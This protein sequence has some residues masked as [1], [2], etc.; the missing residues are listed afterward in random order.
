MLL[1]PLLRQ[2]AAR[3][4]TSTRDPK[5]EDI[6]AAVNRRTLL[7]QFNICG[8]GTAIVRRR[9]HTETPRL[10]WGSDRSIPQPGSR[11]TVRRIGM[12]RLRHRREELANVVTHGF[13]TLCGIAATGVL[14]TLAVLRGDV[15]HIVGAA[16]FG[17]T[18]IVLYSAST[19]YHA[20][21]KQS[22]KDRLRV[23]DHS[24]IYLLI[25]GTYTPFTLAGVRGGWGWALFGVIWGLAAAG[26]LF[27]LFFTGRFRRLSTAIYLAMGWLVVIAAKPVLE[28]LP[29]AALLW[30]AIGGLAYTGGVYFY[31]NRRIPYGHAIWH[32]CVM[33]GST[34]HVVAAALLI[35]LPA[36]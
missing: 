33:A 8:P 10:C 16:V 14:V 30:L 24:A 12:A 29:G 5:G 18:L 9:S 7:F 21:P 26:I 27:K 6:L 31:A 23:V 1:A 19:L 32:L 36:G 20:A 22:V 2:A 13:G 34:A 4:R 17:T 15:F 35:L 25:A 28:A 3:T 11:A